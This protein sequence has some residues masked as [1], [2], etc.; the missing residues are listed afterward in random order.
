MASTTYKLIT[1][2]GTE[3]VDGTFDEAV[4]AAIAMEDRLQ[5]AFGVTVEDEDG[6]TVAEIRDGVVTTE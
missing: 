5:P 4:A 1:T 6:E 2:K 3:T